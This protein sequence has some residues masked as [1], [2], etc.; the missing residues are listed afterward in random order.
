[1]QLIDLLDPSCLSMV[2]QISEKKYFFI[3]EYLLIYQ[4]Q[5]YIRIQSGQW[6]RIRIQNSDP[7]PGGQ[8]WPR[9]VE[10]IK[11]FHVLKCRMFSLRAEGFFCNLGVLYGVLRIGIL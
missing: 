4:Y 10:E 11:K 2:Q 7:D 9:K 6:I 1:M 8:K 5:G 3:S